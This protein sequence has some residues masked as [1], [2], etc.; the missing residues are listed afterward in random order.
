MKILVAGGSGFIGRNFCLMA[1]KNWDCYATYNKS[2]Q[3]PS[4][5]ESHKLQNIKPIHVDMTSSVSISAMTGKIGDTFDVC[6]F[7]LG[8]SDIAWSCK[9]PLQDAFFNINPLLN[10][11]Q[12]TYIKKLVFISSGA[13]YEGRLGQINPSLSISP[14]T[15]YAISKLTSEQYIKFFQAKTTHLESYI[16]LRF[17][18]A[19]GP[20]ELERKIYT[21]LVKTFAIERKS[22]FTLNGNGKNY[23]DAMYIDD[24]IAGIKK[25]IQSDKGN[26]VLDYCFGQ[27]LTINELIVRASQLLGIKEISLTHNGNTAEYTT[28]FASPGQVEALFDFRPQ[29]QLG[30]GLNKL[31]AHLIGNNG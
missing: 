6:L 16:C 26:L 24:A 8:N 22:K 12:N 19:Y 11:L 28:F 15:P 10:L 2:I 14:I 3:F 5:L 29:I 20:W 9:E 7:A 17:F 21:N 25:M 4:F 13:V 18:G 1:D 31:K 30:T 23:I 27:P